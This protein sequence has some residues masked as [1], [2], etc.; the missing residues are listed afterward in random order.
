MPNIKRPLL[1]L[2]V[3][4]SALTSGSIGCRQKPQDFETLRHAV[5]AEVWS[6]IGTKYFDRSMNGFDWDAVKRTYEP[7][8]GEQR[9]SIDLYWKV[10]RPMTEL[11]ETSHVMANPPPAP[12]SG[13]PDGKPKMASGGLNPESCGGLLISFG[14][15]SLRAR[16]MSISSDSLL[17]P[18]GVRVGWRLVGVSSRDEK[19]GLPQTLN[20]VSTDGTDV[21]IDIA[22][23][24]GIDRQAVF[25]ELETLV[26]L[27]AM[28]ADPTTEL[29]MKSLGIGLRIGRSGKVP[30]VVDV[31]TNSEAARS[32]IEP[33]SIVMGWSSKQAGNG[34]ILFEGKLIS[35][36]GRSYSASFKFQLHCNAPDRAA[37]MLAENVL[38]LRFDTFKPD[39]VPWLDEQ[40]S[41]NPHAVILDFRRNGGGDAKAMQKVLGRFLTSG[42]RLAKIMRADGEEILTASSAPSVFSGPLIVLLGPLSASA[43]EVSASA[44]RTNK[45]ALLYGQDTF[46]N[47]L[48][49]NSFQLPDGGILQVATADVLGADGRRLENIGVK[50]DK[51]LKPTLAAIQAGRDVVL[52]SALTDLKQ[53]LH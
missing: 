11:L 26:K 22:E 18:A 47:V 46:G 15:R 29:K 14:P 35:P 51:Q 19:S 30:F 34:E 31:L 3:F 16:I 2:W 33:G 17:R 7:R 24:S 40:L 41:R 49:A 13:S 21:D 1:L 5:F 42:T 43:S 28:G 48:L 37:E 45:R 4:V 38:H 39:V 6:V 23:I 9:D 10:L 36:E 20:L 12:R 32:G 52:E 50:V 27:R 8:V 25:E 44:L 53:S